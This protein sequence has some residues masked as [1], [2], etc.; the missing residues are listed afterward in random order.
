MTGGGLPGQSPPGRNPDPAQ[1]LEKPHAGMTVADHHHAHRPWAT[2]GRRRLQ[3][4]LEEQNL[5][6]PRHG[7]EALING[8]LN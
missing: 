6:P 1:H 8:P 5:P 7:R 2:R 4:Q 3:E